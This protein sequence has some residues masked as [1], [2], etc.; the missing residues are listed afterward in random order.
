MSEDLRELD[1]RIL[2]D[3]YGYKKPTV[4]EA[5]EKVFSSKTN[6]VKRNGLGMVVDRFTE[7]NFELVTCEEMPI[8]E[9]KEWLKNNAEVRIICPDF[10]MNDNEANLII[11]QIKIMNYKVAIISEGKDRYWFVTIGLPV[12]NDCVGDYA[13][14]YDEKLSIAICKAVVNGINEGL[15]RRGIGEKMY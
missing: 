3:F 8:E 7:L 6:R 5:V 12:E 4:N 13:E 1:Y 15:I 14:G 11:E 9:K 10:T 2:Y